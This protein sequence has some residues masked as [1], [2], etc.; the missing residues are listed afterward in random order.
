MAVRMIFTALLIVASGGFAAGL[1][2][3]G[4]LHA[5]IA[6][7]T[8]RIK[9]DPRNP[10]LY[11]ERGGLYRAHREWRLALADCDRALRLVPRLSDARLCRGLTLAAA[12]RHSAAERELTAVLERHPDLVVARVARA[13]VFV[14]LHRPLQADPDY[15]AALARH[16]NPDWYLERAHALQQAGD[17]RAIDVVDGAIE[18]LGPLVTLEDYAIE[19]D[20]AAARYESAVRRIDRIL[21]HLPRA[22]SWLVRRGEVLERGKR[23]ADARQAYGEAVAAIEAMPPARRRTRAIQDVLSRARAGQTRTVA[24]PSSSDSQETP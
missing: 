5:Q 23:A 10:I 2:A 13:R 18:I 7:L 14:T 12:G 20:V 21:G 15:A 11:V 9:G 24:A 16:P 17:A 22:P 19:L 8:A 1:L 3:H 6:A 4:D